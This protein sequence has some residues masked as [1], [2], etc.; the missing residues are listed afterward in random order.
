MHYRYENA[1]LPSQRYLYKKRKIR[2]G[3]EGSTDDIANEPLIS[4]LKD[5]HEDEEIR[6]MDSKS[7]LLFRRQ[8]NPDE[9]GAEIEEADFDAAASY[10]SRGD[11][12]S[13]APS[14]SASFFR[15]DRLRYDDKDDMEEFEWPTAAAL[16][17]LA[18]P[19]RHA[20]QRS[21]SSKH[22]RINFIENNF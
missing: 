12:P 10:F 13:P 19:S 7:A 5:E 2:R 21:V 20:A 9:D 22:S 15:Q 3:F 17:M 11:T 18:T 4:A 14:V 1:H 16:N 8:S 6:S